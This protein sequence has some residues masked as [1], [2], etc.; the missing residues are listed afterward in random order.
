MAGSMENCMYQSIGYIKDS[1]VTATIAA[2]I[3]TIL[4]GYFTH[5]GK[6]LKLPSPPTFSYNKEGVGST[7][8]P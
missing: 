8:I 3:S 5:F 6:E 7:D 4:I 2:I 1:Y